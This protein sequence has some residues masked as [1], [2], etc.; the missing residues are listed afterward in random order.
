MKKLFSILALGLT[1]TT[2]AA[3]AQPQHHK[4]MVKKPIKKHHAKKPLPHRG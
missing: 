4:P 1:A 2:M 3:P